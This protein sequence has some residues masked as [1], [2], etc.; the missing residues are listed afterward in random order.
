M[1]ATKHVKE[2]KWQDSAHRKNA[3]TACLWRLEMQLKIFIENISSG[4]STY[5]STVIITDSMV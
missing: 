1:C 4:D 5:V 2:S 3:K